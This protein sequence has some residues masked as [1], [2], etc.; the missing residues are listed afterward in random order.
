[1]SVRIVVDTR[2]KNSQIPKYLI[3]NDIRVDFASLKVGDYIISSEV[4]VERKTINDL[5]NSIYDGRLFV[6]CSDLIQFYSKPILIIE[7]NIHQLVVNIENDYDGI[8]DEIGKGSYG[9]IT[10]IYDALASIAIIFRIPIIHTPSGEFTSKFLV[11][12][13]NKIMHSG[14][15]LNGPLIKKIKKG[16]KIHLQQLSILSSLP[17]VGD[18]L[19]VKL[20]KKYKT[21][22]RA[23]NA[24][25][26]ELAMIPGFGVARAEKIK[27]TLNFEYEEKYLTHQK[28]L[29]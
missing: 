21:P 2:E 19:A 7:G 9:N 22:L 17:G 10:Q 5:I 28:T 24:S 14:S 1:M 25:V 18:K 26:A 16:N 15:S 23:L 13:T 27:K 6:Q 3:T 8:Y 29:L 4:A 12:L 20:L 11:S